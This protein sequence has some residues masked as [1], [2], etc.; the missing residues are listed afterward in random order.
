M[1][2]LDCLQPNSFQCSDQMCIHQKYFNDGNINCP[3][4][5]CSDESSCYN[6][7]IGIPQV[8]SS[9]R[10]IIGGIAA[11]VVLAVLVPITICCCCEFCRKGAVSRGQRNRGGPTSSNSSSGAA[12]ENRSSSSGGGGSGGGRRHRHRTNRS[13]SRGN[14]H[15]DQDSGAIRPQNVGFTSIVGGEQARPLDD[16]KESPPPTYDS[17]F[18]E[19]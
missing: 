11:A 6:K 8:G 7:T 1:A 3:Y 17:L 15:A 12:G 19:R 16:Q 14:R 18:P 2:Y 10:A 4:P 9:K 13:G 5:K